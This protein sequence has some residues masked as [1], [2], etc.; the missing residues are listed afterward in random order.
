MDTLN[1]DPHNDPVMANLFEFK[2]SKGDIKKSEIIVATIDCLA[3]LGIEKTS[4]AAIAK[5]IGTSKSHVN[6]Y[7]KDKD[8]IF[9]EIYRYIAG[10]YQSY[11]L[12]ELKK[13]KSD[14]ETLDIYLDA[15]FNWCN[16]N[17]NQLTVMFLLYYFCYHK[18]KFR[19][20]NQ[21]IRD[22]GVQRISY[23]LREQLGLKLTAKKAEVTAR[24]IQAIMSHTAV[25]VYTMELTSNERVKRI[26]EARKLIKSLI[27]NNEERILQ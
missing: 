20:L 1:Y 17:Q 25:D 24:G 8:D 3:E 4:F 16:E 22:G 6:Y 18:P 19:K 21:Q 7:F 10:V 14:K 26:K 15:Y 27:Y 11:T 2:L 12:R 13:L 23:V 5:K 9:F